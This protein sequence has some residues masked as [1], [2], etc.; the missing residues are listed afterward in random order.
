M[1]QT[2]HA[3]KLM[4]L[5]TKLAQE[6]SQL[7]GIKDWFWNTESQLTENI[8]V[9]AFNGQLKTYNQDIG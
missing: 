5:Q 4:R 2:L 6:L 1:I 8:N 3:G 7:G 9:W